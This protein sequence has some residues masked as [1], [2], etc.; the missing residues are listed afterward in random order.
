MLQWQLIYKT[1][2][3]SSCKKHPKQSTSSNLQEYNNNIAR[4]NCAT[5]TGFNQLLNAF[6]Q[7][8]AFAISL[9]VS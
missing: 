6:K 9:I 2:F 3:K 8:F 4:F 1:R 7:M 5:C